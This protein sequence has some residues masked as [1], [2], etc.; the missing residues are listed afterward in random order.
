MGRNLLVSLCTVLLLAACGTGDATDDAEEPTMPPS[1]SSVPDAHGQQAREAV[2]DLAKRLGVT[3]DEVVVESVEAVT[4]RD[5]SI[6][7][8]EPGKM[9]TQALVEGSRIV[10][11][12]AGERYEYHS[13][14]Q[15]GVFL[16]ENPT[17]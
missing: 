4:W 2:A 13:G 9:Y 1:E 17:Q 16:C 3:P 14:G 8:A 12:V 10:L 6:G 5:G 7:C 11:S 15:R